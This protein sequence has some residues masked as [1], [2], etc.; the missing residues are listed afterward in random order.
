MVVVFVVLFV[1]EK[2]LCTDRQL[3]D[4]EGRVVANDTG[5]GRKAAVEDRA[6]TSSR[7]VMLNR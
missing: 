3:Q 6:T 2:N 1:E 5:R 4:W 7:V